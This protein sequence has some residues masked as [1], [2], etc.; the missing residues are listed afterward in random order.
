VT[1]FECV[2]L[3]IDA[4][5]ATIQM[6][7]PAK[8]NAMS[9]QLHRDVNAAL[10][11]IERTPGIKVVVLTGVGDSFCAGMDLELCFLATHDDPDAFLA[12]NKISLGWYMRFKE[13]SAVTVAKINGW[14]FGGGV[15]LVGI[16]DLAIA[17]EEAT[18]GISE[19]NFGIFPG[20]GTMWAVA[21]HLNRKQALY[22]SLTGE[23][24]SAARALELGLVN[25][26]V[27]LTELDAETDRVV[28]LLKDKN[29]RALAST[30]QVFE[31]VL[32]MDL[33]EAIEWE[34]AKL[35]ELSYLTNGEWITKALAQFRQRR[36]KPGF[37]A[38]ELE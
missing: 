22:Y 28:T 2:R 21:Q 27:P 25:R 7:R 30:K 32:A 5:V 11:E 38:Y 9:P 10:D 19:I 29:G 37:E 4:S 31:R 16:C 3:A 15:E 36:F 18:F 33:P 1:E 23:P 12:M 14:T 13:L 20:G 6:N 35:H 26:V 8:K 17:A 34:M 24:F